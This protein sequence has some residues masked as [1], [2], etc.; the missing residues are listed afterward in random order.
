MAARYFLHIPHLKQKKK[1]KLLEANTAF[2]GAKVTK[3][4]QARKAIADLAKGDNEHQFAREV[5]AGCWD[6]RDDVQAALHHI[7]ETGK[8]VEPTNGA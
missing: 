4:E 3:T 6:H 8:M 5:L 1:P 2:E 7:A